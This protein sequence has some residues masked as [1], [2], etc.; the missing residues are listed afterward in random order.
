MKP[1]VSFAL[2][3]SGLFTTPVLAATGHLVP[4]RAVYELSLVSGGMADGAPDVSGRMVYEFT[5]APCEGYTTNFRFVVETTDEGGASSIT[6]LRTSNHEEIDGRGFQFLSQTFTND[7]LIED[8]KGTA[9][10]DGD[11]VL[12]VRLTGRDK[13]VQ[14]AKPATFPTTHLLKMIDAAKAGE[15]VIERDVFD[16]SDGGDKIYRTTTVIGPMKTDA[17]TGPGAALGAMP[18]WP[19]TVSYFDPDARSDQT[20]DYTIS[21]KIWE[22]GVSS[23]MT[24]DYGDF[25]LSGRLTQYEPLPE[26]S[27]E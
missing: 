7:V 1:T 8:V 25:A 23:D 24:M 10:I 20:P 5:G 2:V 26:T 18:H 6:D 22:N 15:K 21:F 11:N 13:P 16:G 17:A 9:S 14:F 3:L 27:C 12:S 4:H 19:V